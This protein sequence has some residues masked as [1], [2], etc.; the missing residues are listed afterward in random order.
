M[1]RVAST[2]DARRSVISVA[3]SRRINVRRSTGVCQGPTAG[4]PR[5]PCPAHPA[6]PAVLFRGSCGAHFVRR[7]ASN[8]SSDNLSPLQAHSPEGLPAPTCLQHADD[9]PGRV[10]S[11]YV[12]TSI[13]ELANTR[14][15]L[16]VRSRAARAHISSSCW[17]GEA[18]AFV[19]RLMPAPPGASRPS[20][21]CP[22]GNLV[23]EAW[24]QGSSR[25]PG[26]RHPTATRRRAFRHRVPA[27]PA[28]EP[29]AAPK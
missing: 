17:S 3:S 10:T 11:R 8:A 28:G 16:L 21:A 15:G 13:N 4:P 2:R 5:R 27:R 7:G 29:C 24:S 14:Q 20:P 19:A 23:R 22:T 6:I 9:T 1:P 12:R 25:S 18:T 26:Q